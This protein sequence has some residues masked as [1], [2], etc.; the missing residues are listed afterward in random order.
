MKTPTT[1]S[2]PA[3]KTSAAPGQITILAVDD[4]PA[5]LEIL[6]ELLMNRTVE[7]LTASSVEKAREVWEQNADRVNLVLMDLN[8]GEKGIGFELAR[9]IRD[10]RPQAKVVFVSGT[11]PE[12]LENPSVVEG[13]NY[14]HKPF[15]VQELLSIINSHLDHALQDYGRSN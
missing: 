3:E 15:T 10:S 6:R 5:V 9:Q 2:S 7:V 14:L 13:Y 12:T 1:P 11:P 8:L 4:E